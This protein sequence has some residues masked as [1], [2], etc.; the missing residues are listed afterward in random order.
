MHAPS[1]GNINAIITGYNTW[2]D[3]PTKLFPDRINVVVAREPGKVWARRRSDTWKGFIH[4]AT[5]LEGAIELLEKTG[6]YPQEQKEET[7]NANGNWHIYEENNLPCRG[8][9][10]ITGGAELCRHALNLP[11]VDSLLLTRAMA[12]FKVNTFSLLVLDGRGNQQWCRQTDK[13]CQKWGDSD[14][15]IGVQCENGIEWEVFMF[16]DFEEG[17]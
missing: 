12:G 5:S 17:E 8:R 2:D 6:S 16:N 4:V 15:P 11:W 14:F 7:S 1:N 13:A 3:E 9:I 10:F